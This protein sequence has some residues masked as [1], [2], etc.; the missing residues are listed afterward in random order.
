M[1][2]ATLA[3]LGEN[4]E[5][6]EGEWHLIVVL[7]RIGLRREMVREPR[8]G[9]ERAEPSEEVEEEREHGRSVDSWKSSV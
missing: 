1:K 6:R 7:K 2:A 9:G 5:G 4:T 8:E 3:D